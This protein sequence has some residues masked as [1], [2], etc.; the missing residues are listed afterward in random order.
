VLEELVSIVELSDHDI[1][2]IEMSTVL[3]VEENIIE[4]RYIFI[5]SCVLLQK[6]DKASVNTPLFFMLHSKTPH[7]H[8]VLFV[9]V[10]LNL[11]TALVPSDTACLANSPGSMRRT[12]V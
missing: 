11:V 10:V 2:W 12:A 6:T 1:Q 4:K 9:Y 8:R 3:L 5:K 7:Q